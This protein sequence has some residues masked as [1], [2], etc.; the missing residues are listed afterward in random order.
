MNDQKP[1]GQS[2]LEG[3][4]AQILGGA[5]AI[6]LVTGLASFD[7]YMKAG[8]ETAFGTVLSVS[9]YLG[10]KQLRRR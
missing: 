1:T 4:L 5:V 8:F 9:F 3:T 6:M 7:I 10:F 2:I